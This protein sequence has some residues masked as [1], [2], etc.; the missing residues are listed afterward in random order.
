MPFEAGADTGVDFNFEESC[1]DIG[2]CAVL[3]D[4]DGE[5]KLCKFPPS[6]HPQQQFFIRY[7]SKLFKNLAQSF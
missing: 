7:A 1:E 3:R 2:R 4:P 5:L 6:Q